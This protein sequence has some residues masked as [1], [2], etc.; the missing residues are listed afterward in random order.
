MDDTA[1]PML[2]ARFAEALVFA[3]EVHRHDVRKGS[4]TPYVSH[5]LAVCA[6]TLELGGTEDEAIAAL[7]HD[8]AEDHGGE[9]MLDEI[10]E[11]FGT[12][13]A[14]IVRGLSD[15]L[16]EDAENKAPWRPRKEA[17]LREL[18]GEEDVRVLRVSLAD[19]VH[20]AGAIVREHRTSGLAV[21]ERFK[22]ARFADDGSELPAVDATRGWEQTLW[23]YESLV[24]AYDRHGAVLADGIEQLRT[25]VAEMRSLGPDPTS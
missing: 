24:P 9:A 6:L 16:T 19:K 13:V 25:L 22:P 17:Y 23:Y 3:H 12:D 18:A 14:D 15:S 8:A 10:A 11:R 21:Y 20:N 1:T 5:L 7:L 2:G 4:G